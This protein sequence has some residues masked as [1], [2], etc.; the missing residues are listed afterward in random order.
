MSQSFDSF[1]NPTTGLQSALGFFIKRLHPVMVEVMQE[2]L[3]CKTRKQL[4]IPRVFK[5][6]PFS[7]VWVTVK[8]IIFNYL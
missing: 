8:K 6:N 1:Q 3:F 4:C 2:K 5:L 7:L